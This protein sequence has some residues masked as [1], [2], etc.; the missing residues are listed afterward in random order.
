MRKQ[1]RSNTSKGEA[2][3]NERAEISFKFFSPENAFMQAT[4]SGFCHP[5]ALL[6]SA[7]RKA[8]KLYSL[9]VSHKKKI[10]L[11]KIIFYNSI[12]EHD[13][14]DFAIFCVTNMIDTK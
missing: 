2:I 11:T 1:I 8:L 14:S 12:P 4:F 9:I 7:D 13:I 5:L 10:E 3:K 6:R